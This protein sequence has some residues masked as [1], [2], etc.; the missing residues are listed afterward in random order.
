MNED[1]ASEPHDEG[2]HVLVNIHTN[3]VVE[4]Y[5]VEVQLG[6]VERGGRTLPC[7]AESVRS[8]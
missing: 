8:A 1:C 7:G 3:V 5:M 2:P 6:A 4:A